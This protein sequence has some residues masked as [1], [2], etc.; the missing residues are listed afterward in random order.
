[1][2]YVV[3]YLR[4]G[5]NNAH[6]D[7]KRAVC[8]VTGLPARYR[9]LFHWL[10]FAWQPNFEQTNIVSNFLQ[11]DV[12]HLLC[13][14]MLVHLFCLSDALWI[15][16]LSE[17]FIKN[18]GKALVLNFADALYLLSCHVVGWAGIGTPRQ[19]CPMP[20]RRHLKLFVIGRP[21]GTYVES[22]LSLLNVRPWAD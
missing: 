3:R 5:F 18:N 6:A 1:M 15:H 13:N 10:S 19:A 16:Q 14:T 8:V 20:P 9:H 21:L 17:S 7:P 22:N 11:T 4:T 2:C 12:L